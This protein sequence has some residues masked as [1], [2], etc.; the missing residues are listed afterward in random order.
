MIMRQ[1]RK[2]RDHLRRTLEL[3]AH[4]ENRM[5]LLL[6][7][8]PVAQITSLGAVTLDLGNSVRFTLHLGDNHTVKIGDRLPLYTEIKHVE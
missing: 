5:K 2:E 1:L 8:F 7:E 4:K 3:M 6:G